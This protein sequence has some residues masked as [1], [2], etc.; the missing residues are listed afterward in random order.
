MLLM[1]D[2]TTCAT[3]LLGAYASP[4]LVLRARTHELAER[5]TR[6]RGRSDE[7]QHT[8]TP[9][10]AA[11]DDIPAGAAADESSS[12]SSRKS[13]SDRRDSSHFLIE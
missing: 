6:K 10:G 8:P 2:A 4:M 13:T 1:F 11:T 12:D 5:M 3:F 9:A 7:A